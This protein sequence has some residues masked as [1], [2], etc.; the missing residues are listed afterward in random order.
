MAWCEVPSSGTVSFRRLLPF[1]SERVTDV[2]VAEGCF[3][4]T[5]RAPMLPQRVKPHNC[6]STC[7]PIVARATR[8]GGYGENFTS[9]RFPADGRSLSH[10]ALSL[11]LLRRFV[12]LDHEPLCI[13]PAA[14]LTLDPLSESCDG[15]R[16]SR[17]SLGKA[18]KSRVDTAR[19]CVLPYLCIFIFLFLWNMNRK[20]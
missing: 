20:C 1:S 14:S 5:E 11:H 8:R 3:S 15:D 13:P 6:E 4:A 17:C 10:L 16:H 7:C 9:R 2:C 18:L 12:M 19:R